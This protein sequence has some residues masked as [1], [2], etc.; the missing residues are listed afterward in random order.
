MMNTEV[1]LRLGRPLEARGDELIEYSPWVL[2]W[3][4]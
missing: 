4:A 1:G 3:Y 2:I